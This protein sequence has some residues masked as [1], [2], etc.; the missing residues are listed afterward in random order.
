[1]AEWIDFS[2][3]PKE[4]EYD[5]AFESDAEVTA[6]KQNLTNLLPGKKKHDKVA[7]KR[8]LEEELIKEEGKAYRSKA[9]ALDAVS[10][11]IKKRTFV[12]ILTCITGF[13]SFMRTTPFK[14]LKT[15]SM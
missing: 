9:V 15:F 12:F 10:F 4:R 5:S 1:M 14:V 3:V 6:R 2:E 7:N 11:V 8:Q 13:S